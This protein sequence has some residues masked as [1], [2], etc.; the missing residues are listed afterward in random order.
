MSVLIKG[1]DE[2]PEDRAVLVVMHDNGKAYIKHA[3]TYGYSMEL[4]KL[5]ETHGRLIDAEKLKNEYQHDT[6]WDY[7][8]NTNCYVCESIDN[9]STVI[10][11]EGKEC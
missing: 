4:V 11:A 8:V 7:P 5:P 10:E 6:D 2:I 9:A 3:C 1:M